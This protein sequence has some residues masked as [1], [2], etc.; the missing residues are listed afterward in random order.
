MKV[1]DSEI[2][3]CKRAGG[4]QGLQ[5]RAIN[6][7]TAESHVS[8]REGCSHAQDPRSYFP[9]SHYIEITA[10]SED[11]SLVLSSSYL[12]LSPILHGSLCLYLFPS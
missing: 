2:Y 11:L 10:Y 9:L 3:P 5:I 6:R 12:G 8:R 4:L 7:Q 1:S